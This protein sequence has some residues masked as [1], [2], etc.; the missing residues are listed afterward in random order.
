LQKIGKTIWAV[1]DAGLN[2]KGAKAH[3]CRI[4]EEKLSWLS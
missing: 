1:I 2:S 3:G 4:F